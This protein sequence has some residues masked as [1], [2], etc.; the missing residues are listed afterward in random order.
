M[1]SSSSIV[2]SITVVLK[3]IVNSG[4]VGQK[5]WISFEQGIITYASYV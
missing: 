4:Y 2:L 5:L 3:F 1:N